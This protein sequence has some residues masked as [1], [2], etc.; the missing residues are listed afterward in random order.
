MERDNCILS[1]VAPN[2]WKHFQQQAIIR[3]KERNSIEIKDNVTWLTGGS[4]L[5]LRVATQPWPTKAI[6][7]VSNN[8]QQLATA[9]PKKLFLSAQC[10]RRVGFLI[11]M[12]MY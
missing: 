4:Q 7:S 12:I 5:V 2:E 8:L 10:V 9:A 11:C 6:H 1:D 3:K